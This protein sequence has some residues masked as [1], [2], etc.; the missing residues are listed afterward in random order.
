MAE[1]EGKQGMKFDDVRKRLKRINKV[2]PENR[3]HAKA[4]NNL[5]ASLLNQVRRRDG[6]KAARE[7]WRA[8]NE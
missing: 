6:N 3:S 1:W 5:Q 2:K 8:S 4:K 7:V